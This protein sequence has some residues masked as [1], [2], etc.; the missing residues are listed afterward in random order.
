MTEQTNLLAKLFAACWKDADLK[1]RFQ[2]NPAQV[3]AEYGMEVPEG[4][5]VIVVENSDSTVHITLPPSPVHH[6]ELSDDE[7]TNAAGGAGDAMEI[8]VTGIICIG[9]SPVN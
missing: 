3:L 9:T 1:A 7:L 6:N 5:D 2:S 8:P 4:I